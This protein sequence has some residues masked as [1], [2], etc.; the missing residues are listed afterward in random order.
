MRDD[1][2]SVRGD[3]DGFSG[4]RWILGRG[5][6]DYMGKEGRA[7]RRWIHTDIHWRPAERGNTA[8]AMDSHG[9]GQ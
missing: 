6:M 3:P 5:T 8:L 2:F 1:G 4:G 9:E 7:E